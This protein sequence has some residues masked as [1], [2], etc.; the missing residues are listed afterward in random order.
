[1]RPSG[2]RTESVRP[3]SAWQSR[4]RPSPRPRPGDP[5]RD[6]WAGH[7]QRRE[8]HRQLLP[9]PR[10]DGRPDGLRFPGRTAQLHPPGVRPRHLPVPCPSVRANVFARRP[11]GSMIRSCKPSAATAAAGRTQMPRPARPADWRASFGT[12]SFTTSQWPIPTATP[13]MPPTRSATGR[14]CATSR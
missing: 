6:D 3:G 11:M 13:S 5:S 2:D 12:G 4:M 7:L 1:M 8:R 14:S 10:A 9:G